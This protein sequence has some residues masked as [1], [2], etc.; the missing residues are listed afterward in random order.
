[1]RLGLLVSSLLLV[2][3]APVMAQDPFDWTGFYAGVHAGGG[4]G[5]V[6]FETANDLA[7]HNAPGGLVGAQAGYNADIGNSLLL[8]VEA[9]LSWTNMSGEALVDEAPPPFGDQYE[10]TNFHWLATLAP[11]LGYASGNWFVYGKLGVAY[12][13]FDAYFDD[14]TGL[15]SLGGSRFGAVFGLGAEY[16][17]DENWSIRGEYDFINLGN[18]PR[19]FAPYATAYDAEMA[20]H[21]FTV[22]V[23][24]RF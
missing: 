10:G 13:S 14:D 19:K 8:G 2:S 11:R 23:N 24:Y 6:D 15:D 18:S 9:T 16:A 22:G 21:A 12:A 20:I 7:D 5:V 4:A 1:M 3:S 17:I